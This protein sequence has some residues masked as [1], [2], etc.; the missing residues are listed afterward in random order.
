ML[1]GLV[2][3]GRFGLLF[4]IVEGTDIVDNCLLNNVSNFSAPIKHFFPIESIG[5]SAALQMDGIQK[6]NTPFYG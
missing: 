2:D 3:D 4:F 5:G 6:T 1:F